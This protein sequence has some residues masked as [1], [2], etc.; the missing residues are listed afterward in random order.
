[1]IS[2]E[3]TDEPTVLNICIPSLDRSQ[4]ELP[5]YGDSNKDKE[6]NMLMERMKKAQELATGQGSILIEVRVLP[7]KRAVSVRKR[8]WRA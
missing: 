4:R 3:T 1:M 5:I 8:R 7:P 6:Y 2:A